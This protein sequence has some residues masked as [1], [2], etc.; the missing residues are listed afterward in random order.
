MPHVDRGERSRRLCRPLRRR[1]EYCPLV[2]PQRSA[3]R[4]SKQQPETTAAAEGKP[5]KAA[6]GLNI[7]KA[8]ARASGLEPGMVTIVK[9]VRLG[10]FVLSGKRKVV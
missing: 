1:R 10:G 6:K 2:R 5:E 8:A 9:S 4:K 3:D 7:H